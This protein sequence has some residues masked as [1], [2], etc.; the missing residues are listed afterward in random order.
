M[1]TLWTGQSPAEHGVAGYELWLRQYGIV[2]NM[3]SQSPMSFKGSNGSLERAGFNPD[4]ELDMPKLGEYLRTQGV[5]TYSFQHY[6]IA[7]SGLS[8][9]YLKD[10][11][12]VPFGTDAECWV[13]LR[14]VIERRKDDKLYLWTYWG[15]YDGLAH[16]YGPDDERAELYFTN[17]SQSLAYDFIDRLLPEL[18]KGTLLILTADH[19][20]VFTPKLPDFNLNNHP[21]FMNCLHIKPTGENRLTYLHVKPGK[22]DTVREYAAKTWPDQFILANSKDLL[23]KGLFGPGNPMADF[24]NRIGDF[25]MIAKDHNYLWWSEEDNPLLGRHGGLTAQE[26]LVPYLAVRL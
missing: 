19:G 9:T 21:E 20:Q 11:T 14:E 10:V 15:S 5:S 24:H 16:R 17:F 8:R 25:I 6:S 3:I 1:T 7:Y 22:E 2:A 12:V 13:N 23:D 26:M 4:T 18:R